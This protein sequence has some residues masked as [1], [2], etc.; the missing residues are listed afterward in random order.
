MRAPKLAPAQVLLSG[1]RALRRDNRA[2]AK[3][4]I[5]PQP[6][7]GRHPHPLAWS[8]FSVTPCTYCH[9][10]ALFSLTTL[11]VPNQSGAVQPVPPLPDSRPHGASQLP[12]GYTLI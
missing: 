9:A 1:I 10:L 4:T 7:G 6:I 8:G 12:E 2:P 5:M 11:P 3:T